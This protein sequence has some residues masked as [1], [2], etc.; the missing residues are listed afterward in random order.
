MLPLLESMLDSNDTIFKYNRK[1]NIYSVIPYVNALTDTQVA[2]R[3]YYI[4]TSIKICQSK[5]PMF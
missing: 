5:H 1:R 2:R 3:Y 4:T